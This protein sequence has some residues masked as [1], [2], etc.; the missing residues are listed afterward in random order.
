[1]RYAMKQLPKAL[2]QKQA[3]HFNQELGMNFT[4]GNL[5]SF[6]FSTLQS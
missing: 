2:Q 5:I 6:F 1:M 3:K 4:I